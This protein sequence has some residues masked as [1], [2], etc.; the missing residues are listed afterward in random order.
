MG[1][2]GG[3]IKLRGRAKATSVGQL[4]LWNTTPVIVPLLT[5]VCSHQKQNW[6][7]DLDLPG[8]DRGRA[9][10]AEDELLTKLA[11]T[12]RGESGTYLGMVYVNRDFVPGRW[13]TL[14]KISR[15]AGGHRVPVALT[16][17][18]NEQRTSTV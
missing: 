9:G 12:E 7:R 5:P 10:L 16:L 13:W 6:V 17:D 1:I 14:S 4:F 11:V 15:T 8:L 2:G 3:N 18:E